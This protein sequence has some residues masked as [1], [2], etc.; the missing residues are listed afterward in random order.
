MMP[1]GAGRRVAPWLAAAFCY[2]GL[3]VALTWPLAAHLSTVLP[4][5]LG[6]PVLNTWILWW[7][8]HTV[9]ASARWWN[10]PMFWPAQGA[11]AF[12]EHLLGI[13]VFGTP[14]QWMG[15]SAVTA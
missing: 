14:I 13:S 9:P 7:N 5:D 11:F 10:A 2:A 1:P 3:A 4:H 6:D 8:A 12:S 15:G